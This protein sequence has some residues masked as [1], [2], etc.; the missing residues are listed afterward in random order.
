MKNLPIKL[1]EQNWDKDTIPVVSVFSWVFNH[2]D[3]IRQSLESILMQETTFPVEIII[4]D[5]AS[6]DGTRKIIEQ[7]QSKYPNLFKNIFFSENQ[8]SQGKSIMNELFKKPKGKYISLIHGDDYWTDPNKL[9]K[10]VDFLEVNFN[11]NVHFHNVNFIIKDENSS[12]VVNN[13]CNNHMESSREIYFEEL[14]KNNMISTPSVLYRSSSLV[15]DRTILRKLSFGD[16]YLHLISAHKSKVYC[17][18]EIMANY[19]IHD[20]GV[21]SGAATIDKI[22]ANWKFRKIMD[23]FFNFQY[24][25][26]FFHPLYIT[27]HFEAAIQLNNGYFKRIKLYFQYLSFKKRT[28]KSWGYYFL[29]LRRIS[30]IGLSK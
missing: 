5:D 23:Q 7:Y 17:D 20:N 25:E 4:Q 10:Q 24:N 13:E 15:I 27:E 3:F 1:T 22:N 2:K 26:Y 21:W 12:W 14:V 6:N 19:R 28:K 9:Q 8:H 11:F 30:R 29:I 18:K 16:Y